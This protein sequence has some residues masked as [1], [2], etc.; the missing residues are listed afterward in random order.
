MRKLIFISISLILL[1][2]G[3]YAQDS[4]KQKTQTIDISS[5]QL[6]GQEGFA[7]DVRLDAFDS[8]FIRDFDRSLL[9]FSSDYTGSLKNPGLLFSDIDFSGNDLLNAGITFSDKNN[10]QRIILSPFR[11]SDKITNNILLNTKFRAA[12]K[13]NITTLGLAIGGDNNDQNLKK[14]KDLRTKIFSKGKYYIPECFDTKALQE[15]HR[16]K[17]KEI[18]DSLLYEY[19]MARTKNVLKWNIGYSVQIFQFLSTKS[20]NAVNDSLNYFGIKSNVISL[21]GSYSYKNG[22]FLLTGDYNLINSRKSAEKGQEKI[23][24]HGLLFSASYRIIAFIKRKDKLMAN[25]DFVKSLFVPGIHLGLSYEYKTTNGELN[26]IED[27]IIKNRVITP[28]VD[29]LITPS[30]AFRIGFPLIKNKSITDVK[31]AQTAASI[32]YSFKLS[33]LN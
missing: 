11:L 20:E 21:G 15:I 25:E 18:A 13:N 1:E 27:G 9:S 31:T 16:Q 26:F 29:F 2:H 4:C 3:L 24:Y 6:V 19:D 32:Q 17:N 14:I 12:V 8:E 23:I 33:N 10:V 7:T 5:K 28:Y 30:S 22:K